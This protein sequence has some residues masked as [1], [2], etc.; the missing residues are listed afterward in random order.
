MKRP[1]FQSIDTHT[2]L[3]K[4]VYY[5]TLSTNKGFLKFVNFSLLKSTFD[6]LNFKKVMKFYMNNYLTSK[7]KKAFINVTLNC[8]W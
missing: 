7:W 3:G 6:G 1:F 2:H 8:S 5:Y 4:F